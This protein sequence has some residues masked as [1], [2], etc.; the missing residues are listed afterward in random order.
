[1]F[2][3]VR[4]C[5]CVF[6]R[7]NQLMDDYDE[8]WED[9]VINVVD[10]EAWETYGD[11]SIVDD[12]SEYCRGVG[13]VGGS[14]DESCERI[15]GE[16]MSSDDSKDFDEVSEAAREFIRSRLAHLFVHE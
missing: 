11:D 1:V 9:N 8:H 13:G 14:E 4:V 2:V 7:T 6:V 3:C 16:L 5:S 10:E 12:E 15:A